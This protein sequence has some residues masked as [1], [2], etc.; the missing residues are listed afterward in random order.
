MSYLCCVDFTIHVCFLLQCSCRINI[1]NSF[2]VNKISWGLN[3]RIISIGYGSVLYTTY[4]TL[5]CV[6]VSQGTVVPCI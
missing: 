5:L 2:A 3:K 1:E 6:V 4:E